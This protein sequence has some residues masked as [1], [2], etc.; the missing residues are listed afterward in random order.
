MSTRIRIC[1]S[2]PAVPRPDARLDRTNATGV[3]RATR[4]SGDAI[5]GAVVCESLYSAYPDATEGELTRIKSV[6]VSRAT[7]AELT[8][9]L[10]LEQFLLLGR[11][12]D[13]AGQI[14]GSILA[15]VFESVVGAI[16][17]DGGYEIAREF[18]LDA[19]SAQVQQAAESMTGVNFKSLFQQFSQR[20]IGVT[21]TYMVLDEQGPDHSEVLSGG[22]S[23]RNAAVRPGMGAEQEGS[24]QLAAGNALAEC[25]GEALPYPLNENASSPQ[26]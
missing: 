20:T 25:E 16:Y 24:R 7:C 23:G 6:A 26:T 11:G 5:L 18:V 17:L 15:A 22:G 2:Q 13:S 9:E 12:V 1:R 10:G 19:I 21:P 4:V 3:E 8:L 14:P